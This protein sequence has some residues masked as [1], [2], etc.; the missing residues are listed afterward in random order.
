MGSAAISTAR[1]YPAVLAA[2]VLHLA[3]PGSSNGQIS[4]RETD[5]RGSVSG[6]DPFAHVLT[7]GW[8]LVLYGH[9]A[10]AN[11]ALTLDDLG[12]LVFL[13][14]RDSL[15]VGDALDAL[16]L[17]PRGEG[18]AADGEAGTGF[19]GGIP[20]GHGWTVGASMGARGWS[21]GVA[22]EDAV[23]LLRD[24]NAD[25]TEFSLGTTRGDALLAAEVGAHA[26]WQ[27][28][29][30]VGNDGPQLT[31]AGGLRWVR[32]LF[33][34]RARS[35]LE[36][37]GRIRI[38]PDSVRAKLAVVT[39][40]T[41]SVQL[42]GGG[43]LGDALVRAAW[44]ESEFAVEASV[45][46]IGAVS[47]DRVLRRREEV[48]IATTRLDSVVDVVEALSFEV[49]DS[50]ATSVSPPAALNLTA[51][52][53]SLP[54]V[55]LDVRLKVPMGGDFHRPPPTVGLISTFRPLRMLP[56]LAGLQLGG[57]ADVGY[58]VGAGWEGERLFARLSAAT[59]GG[60]FGG[61]R[62]VTADVSFGVRF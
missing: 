11:S 5:R 35:L 3:V 4:P 44:P 60:F 52:T 21:T 7:S 42:Q 55:Q 34:G 54:S 32:P 58:R 36:D 25:R 6:Q 62:G 53:W 20:V 13:A 29:R 22:D 14:D 27:A 16:G 38:T 24:G 56:L 1:A 61:A 59:G 51:S 2:L 45:S 46:G 8:S 26:G 18:L 40:E 57:H 48:N 31:F 43:V 10:A 37:G 30:I 23:S 28:G 12:A 9:G 50:V 17:I 49:R 41:P 19:Q 33:Y 15:R 47:I 39:A